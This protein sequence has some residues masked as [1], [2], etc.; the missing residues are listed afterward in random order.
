MRRHGPECLRIQH[1]IAGQSLLS[2]SGRVSQ[3]RV[4][5]IGL[6]LGLAALAAVP[7]V[8]DLPHL[9]ASECAA[10]CHLPDVL[11]ALLQLPGPGPV[12][13]AQSTLR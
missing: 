6:W 1:K 8:V 11:H 2:V 9:G 12:A 4:D 5:R 13:H 10:G 3:S 7:A